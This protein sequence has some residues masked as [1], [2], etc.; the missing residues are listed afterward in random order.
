MSTRRRVEGLGH[1]ES[2]L[3]STRDPKS[4][5]RS[6][7]P[8]RRIACLLPHQPC[9]RGVF[10]CLSCTYRPPI[11]PGPLLRY[12]V[13]FH[14]LSNDGTS[15]TRDQPVLTLYVHQTAKSTFQSCSDSTTLPTACARSQ[16]T[17]QPYG[18]CSA[19]RAVAWVGL[20]MC[21]YLLL[22]S[23]RNFLHLKDLP[24]EVVDAREEDNGN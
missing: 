3:D 21:T 5:L 19:V 9:S 20:P 6:P 16:P 22:R 10:A 13:M 23:F 1:L 18:D 11:P 24:I 12:C 17:R 8:H 4:V 7:Q 15:N 14:S 2:S